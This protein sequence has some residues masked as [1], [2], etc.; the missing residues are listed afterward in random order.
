MRVLRQRDNGEL[1]RIAGQEARRCAHG[2]LH[3]THID[4][5]VQLNK[6]ISLCGL[7]V[8]KFDPKRANYVTRSS[9]PKAI[10]A[11]DACD[12]HGFNSLFF[13]AGSFGE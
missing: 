12:E 11:C 9:I 6:V 7:C 10:G 4:N 5:L 3:G 13:K 8:S 1:M 2:K